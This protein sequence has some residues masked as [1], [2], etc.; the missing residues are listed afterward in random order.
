MRRRV[1]IFLE[2]ATGFAR[3]VLE[4][5]AAYS[6]AWE[7]LTEEWGEIEDMGSLDGV[8]GAIK[9]PELALATRHL[10]C[11]NLDPGGLAPHHPA[12]LVDELA[13]GRLA[14]Q[15]FLDRGLRSLALLGEPQEGFLE[16]ARQAAVLV[17]VATWDD[18]LEL[19]R[20]TGLFVTDALA[21]R[22]VLRMCRQTGVRTPY[23]LAI[24]GPDARELAT[25]LTSPALSSI[26]RPAA[27]IG[28]RAAELL[29]SL[30]RGHP[31]PAEPVL[32]A[33]T[34]VCTRESSDIRAVRDATVSAAL[35]FIEE[36]LGDG[37]CVRD[38][39]AHVAT[40][41]RWLENKFLQHLGRGPAAEIRRMQIERVCNL[42]LETDW[43][44]KQISSACGLSS[45]EQ[46]Q[47][48]FKRE[49]GMPPGA[50]RNWHRRCSIE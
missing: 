27:E 41:R 6:Q 50:F 17:R 40:S 25:R 24:L 47:V 2:L 16:C 35:H 9:S 10:P 34:G 20:P 44:I 26:I 39:A 43:P 33:P 8:I 36:H 4:G 1:G 49:L 30:W 31:S 18:I 23:D 48:L 32:V 37:L 28:Y 3:H 15:H 38:V 42:L 46:L 5:V 21:A 11:V 7:L 19:P 22:R 45:P 12:V 13:V 14:A 29:D